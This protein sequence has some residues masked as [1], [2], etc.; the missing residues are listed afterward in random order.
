MRSY[1]R[2]SPQAAARIVALA[3]LADGNLSPAELDALVESDAEA[4]LGLKPGEWHDVVDA[5]CEDLM[6]SQHRTLSRTCKIDPD[7]LRALMSE[8]D[9]DVLRRNV[10]DLCVSVIDADA[11][12]VEA[13]MIVLSAAA[14][15]WSLSR[16]SS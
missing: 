12:I 13:E 4:L 10:L 5:F 1:P 14:R 2:N 6:S 8:I 9:D 7:T 3:M 16:V 11:E 15:D